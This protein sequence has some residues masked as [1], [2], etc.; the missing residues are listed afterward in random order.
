MLTELS[1]PFGCLE[2]RLEAIALDLSTQQES[3]KVTIVRT[4]IPPD[5]PN[6]ELDELMEL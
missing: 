1:V 4:V 3:H 2:I 6:F 5:L